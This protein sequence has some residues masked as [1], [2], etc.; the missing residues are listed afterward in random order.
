MIDPS[1]FACTLTPFDVASWYVCVLRQTTRCMYVCMYVSYLE[2]GCVCY[3]CTFVCSVSTICLYA[4]VASS[5]LMRVFTYHIWCICRYMYRIW[6][7]ST[8]YLML[9]CIASY[10][11][12]CMICMSQLHVCMYRI[13]WMYIILLCMYV[14]MYC[15]WCM[16]V[17]IASV[18]H[19]IQKLMKCVGCTTKGWTRQWDLEEM[20]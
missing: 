16:H 14:C 15:I 9:V 18:L 10:H 1:R 11:I 17:C 2:Y 19:D 4:C 12:W 7:T 8:S 3:G 5:Y 13:W 6:C 20:K